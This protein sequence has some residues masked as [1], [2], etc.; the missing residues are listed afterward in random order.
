[1][2][3]KRPFDI[4][5]LRDSMASH[6]AQIGPS[7]K[8]KLVKDFQDRIV[9]GTRN[10]SV[11][12]DP[13]L[14]GEV[15]RT[16]KVVTTEGIR[17]PSRIERTAD[18]MGQAVLETLQMAALGELQRRDNDRFILIADAAVGFQQ[19]L[20]APVAAERY[21]EGTGYGLPGT[22]DLTIDIDE[23][24][25]TSSDVSKIATSLE[26][27][28]TGAGV[29]EDL[30][31]DLKKGSSPFGPNKQIPEFF[32]VGAELALEVWRITYPFTEGM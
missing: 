23:Y 5:T 9:T 1:M 28:R 7:K 19:A 12:R 22:G 30:I 21:F 32:T 11:L 14:V 6:A 2:E 27:D 31:K 18:F 4:N 20:M 10:A 16:S 17:A 15:M 8:A 24:M 13:K 25:K 26:H 3:N 29:I